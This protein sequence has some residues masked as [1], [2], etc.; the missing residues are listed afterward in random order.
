MFK[1]HIYLPLEILPRELNSKLLLG[2]YAAKSGFRVYLG[3]KESINYLLNKKKN[4]K[5]KAGIFF[6]KGQ[7]I[8]KYKSM[9][10]FISQT[11]D[12]LV[13][14]D[15]ELGVAVK[16]YTHGI[17]ERLR[18]FNSINQFYCIGKKLKKI[19]NKSRKSF[20][21]KAIVTGWPRIDLWSPKFNGLFESEVNKLRK[22]YGEY[23]LFSSDFG[24]ISKK[25]LNKAI[26]QVKKTKSFQPKIKTFRKN[27]Y[28]YQEFKS[29]I[30]KMA[31]K[32]NKKIIIR[33]HPGDM[34]HETWFK[35]F[36]NSKNIRVIYD[37]DISPWILGSSGLIHRGCSTAIQA[38]FNRIPVFY[39]QSKQ[40][41]EK[42]DKLISYKISNKF[43]TID[44]FLYLVKKNKS[45]LRKSDKKLISKEIYMPKNI[46]SSQLIVNN[47]KKIKIKK[48]KRFKR[49][50][51]NFFKTSLLNILFRFLI[52]INIKKDQFSK[53]YMQKFPYRI[54]SALLQKKSKKLFPNSNFTFYSLSNEL[55]EINLDR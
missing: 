23:Y 50:S 32:I 52:K 40:K 25:G 30:K 47:L 45:S 19:I 42:K 17:N 35:D 28:D 22:I 53:Q 15:E 24:A 55:I 41:L 9:T 2:L 37:D 43:R 38:S 46:T 44:Q 13:V 33:P 4:N 34:Y 54:N 6:Y 31:L 20:S 1:K 21:K 7:F 5:Q 36:K 12:E 26:K 16:D 27:Y 14:L 39:W 51:F 10:K 11:C 48:E 18:N 29:F 8:N 3:S 49:D